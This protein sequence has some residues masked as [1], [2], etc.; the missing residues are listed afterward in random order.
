MPL[1][2]IR[3]LL[4]HS[5]VKMTERYAHLAA[6]QTAAYMPL[7]SAAAPLSLASRKACPHPDPLPQT[8]EGDRDPSAG[9]QA[10]PEHHRLA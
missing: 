5:S 10:G 9:P 4:G 7:L 1:F 8:G 2:L 3:G 6:S